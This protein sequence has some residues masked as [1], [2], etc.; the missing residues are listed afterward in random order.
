M[1]NSPLVRTEKLKKSFGALV[2]NDEVTMEVSRGEIR[3]IIGPNGSGKSTFF[4]TLSSFYQADSGSV[5]FKSEEVTD[6]K[7]HQLPQKG[8]VRTFQIVQPFE[9]LTVRE[10]L[11]AAYSSGLR[12][13]ERK[14]NRAEE[15]L[16][17]IELT[18]LA[19]DKAK[20]LSGG[21]QKLLEFGRTLMLDPD[22]VLLDEPTA[23]VNP[24]LADRLLDYIKEANDN[25]TSFV[26]IEHDMQVM[27]DIS[28][29]VSVFNQGEII[30]EGRFEEIKELDSVRDAYMG[31][32]DDE[33][34]MEVLQ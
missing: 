18:E 11:L 12:I 25:G 21:Q 13:S 15:I 24:A 22:C 17:L 23:G 7:P 14:R 33:D 32:E 9:E 10:N 29:K 34:I 5:Y 31:G 28:D 8:L 27:E 3:G 20:E 1:E 16:A 26:I 30:V 19:E 6:L 2:A 4:N